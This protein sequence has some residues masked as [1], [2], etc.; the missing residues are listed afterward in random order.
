L[1]K[2]VRLM[3]QSIWR[4]ALLLTVVALLVKVMSA[5]YRIPYQNVTGDL[6]FYVYGQIYP[7]YGLA[8]VLATHGFPAAMSKL[9]AAKRVEDDNGGVQGVFFQ[10][11]FVL[12]IFGMFA[13]IVLYVGAPWISTGMRDEKLLFPLRMISFS[14][15][16]LPIVASIRGFFQGHNRM[17]VTAGSQLLEQFVRVSVILGLSFF[18][19]ARGYGAYAAGTAAAVG[20][21]AGM[22]AA[23][24]VLILCGLKY[25]RND[26]RGDGKQTAV[27]F[28]RI[29]K[30]L[31]VEG[32]AFSISSLVLVFFMFVDAMTV[33]TLLDVFQEGELAAK[34][35]KGIYDRG[36]PLI[37]LG[38][39][40]AIAFSLSLVPA[41]AKA[42][43]Q[44]DTTQIK[45]NTELAV[46]ISVVFGLGAS[47]GLAA[48][49][50][51]VNVMLY[52]NASGSA[53]I[54]ML[55]MTIL[56]SSVAMTVSGILQGVGHVRRP[57]RHAFFGVA[58]KMTLNVLL[59]PIFGSLGAAA[60]TVCA[61]ALIAACN[62]VL[63]HRKIGGFSFLTGVKY[64]LV[65]ALVVM[66]VIV[67]LWK[68]GVYLVFDAD[69]GDRF[70]Q[71]TIALG[72]TMAGFATYGFMLL[73]LRVF[74]LDEINW[75][76]KLRKKTA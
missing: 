26:K 55:G 29:F 31:S 32:M 74:R 2:E 50:M 17:G 10:S 27:P 64:Q 7:F 21:S 23:A 15:L 40:A 1:G 62:G 18:L 42:K 57:V 76:G 13:F 35:A 28:L 45:K 44:K 38:T 25:R 69:S 3:G 63:L 54:A 72:G 73:R 71:T 8:V 70:S 4:G 67:S 43:A 56:F 37:Q 33:V 11:F 58:A 47:F 6:G 30:M 34:R 60:A 22:A 9:V 68:E 52:K 24:I 20:S 53:V 14:F 12:S 59:I 5:A 48:L 51:P 41:I 39:A 49:A 61:F 66:V 19:I 16:F 36:Y 65:T 75:I 46:K